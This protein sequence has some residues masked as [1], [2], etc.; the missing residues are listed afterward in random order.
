MSNFVN[1]RA[2]NSYEKASLHLE[3]QLL[4]LKSFLKSHKETASNLASVGD[5]NHVSELLS[6]VIEFLGDSNEQN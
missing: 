3:F 2:E 5:L 6:E 4:Q 1:I